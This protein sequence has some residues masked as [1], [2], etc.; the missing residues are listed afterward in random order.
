M[1]FRR[2]NNKGR[3]FM[4][5][6][7][8]GHTN[9]DADND[10]YSSMSFHQLG[11][12]TSVLNRYTDRNSG[13]NSWGITAS[14]S[15]PIFKNHFLQFRYDFSHS[16][17]NSDSKV[18][19]NLGDYLD[20]SNIDYSDS[21]SSKLKNYYN[22]HSFGISLR[23]NYTKMMYS[24]GISLTPQSSKSVT[25]VPVSRAKTLKQNVINFAPNVMFRFFL[26]D[27]IF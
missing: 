27:S 9:T 8:L 13:N 14:Y 23:G 22:S 15:E 10:S 4:I 24:V 17:S 18:Y 11:D 1:L 12:S 19:N 2:L 26:Q 25:E 21:L 5:G 20:H 3:S 7:N 6:A 16:L